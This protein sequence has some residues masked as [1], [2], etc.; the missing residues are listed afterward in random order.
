MK[1]NKTKQIKSKPEKKGI[2][3]FKK[4]VDFMYEN[5]QLMKEFPKKI[6]FSDN[7]AKVEFA[8]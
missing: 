7:T 6:I 1:S 2:K 5:P 4:F 8:N 3:A